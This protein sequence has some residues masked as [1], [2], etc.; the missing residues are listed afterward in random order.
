MTVRPVIDLGQELARPEGQAIGF[1][2]AKEQFDAPV[3]LTVD[4]FD[5]EVT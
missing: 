1:V 2:D 5:F 3:Q 4:A